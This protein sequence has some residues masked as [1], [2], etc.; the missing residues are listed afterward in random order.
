MRTLVIKTGA[1][2]DVLRTTS[3]LPGLAARHPGLEVTW[4]TARGALPLVAHHR[5]VHAV[6]GV[7]PQDEGELDALARRLAGTSWQRVLSFDDEEPLCRLASTVRAAAPDAAFSGAFLAAGGERAYTDDVAPWFDMGLIS[8]FGKEEADRLKIANRETHPAIFAA[9]LGI[10]RG[11]PEL[12]LPPEARA[13]GE[14]FAARAGLGAR[15]PRIGL[16]TGA[17][18][19]WRTKELSVERTVELARLVSEA[20]GG[21]ATFLVLG[22][23]EEAR[24]NAELLDR[25]RALDPPV[26]AVDAGTDNPLLEFAAIVAQVDLLVTSDSLALHVGIA[27]DRR[28]VCF[29]APTSAEEIELYGLGEKVRST[30]PDYCSYRPDADNASITPEVLS[31]KVLEV[32]AR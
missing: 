9:M 31:A 26:R 24:R 8:R 16:N 22:G 2:G 3:V 21:E 23:Q 10:E 32:L 7:A 17:G 12:P 18:G 19:R 20:T 28:I 5:L 14:A 15:A 25:L 4:I 6:E 13:F 30:A 27:L 29:F 11:K 1:L